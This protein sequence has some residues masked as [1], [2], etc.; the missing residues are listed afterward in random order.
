[1]R[2]MLTGCTVSLA[3]F[4]GCNEPEKRLNAPPHGE[5]YKTAD[6]QGTLVYMADNATLADMSMNDAHFLPHRASLNG[7]GLERISRLA[8]LIQAHGGTIRLNTDECAEGLTS[9]R[10]QSIRDFLSEAGV[11]VAGDAVV[12]DMPGGEGLGAAENMLIRTNEGMYKPGA[13]KAGGS[14]SSGTNG[15]DPPK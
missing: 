8:Q 7:L 2:R 5:P 4:A 14:G 9:Q 15:G 13:N 12:C 11:T 3:V 6:S 1:M 10:M